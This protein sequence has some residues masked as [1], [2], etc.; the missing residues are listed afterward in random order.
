MNIDLNNKNN[1]FHTIDKNKYCARQAT[2]SAEGIIILQIAE[3]ANSNIF[4]KYHQQQQNVQK[5]LG[6]QFL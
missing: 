2:I 1:A 5:K 3:I 4:C 6:Q